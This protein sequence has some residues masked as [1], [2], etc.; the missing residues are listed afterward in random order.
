MN[1]KIISIPKM[2][3]TMIIYLNGQPQFIQ[4]VS[5]MHVRWQ[6]NERGWELCCILLEVY[7]ALSGLLVGDQREDHGKRRRNTVPD[8]SYEEWSLSNIL[9]IVTMPWNHQQ[10][11]R[12]KFWSRINKTQFRSSKLIIDDRAKARRYVLNSMHFRAP[13]FFLRVWRFRGWEQQYIQE[14]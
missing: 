11:Q 13:Y 5:V 2:A 9:G 7:T 3:P 1:D 4:A 8:E 6:E 12:T 10:T 14:L